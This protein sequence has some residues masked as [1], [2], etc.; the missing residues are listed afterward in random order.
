M[1][2]RAFLFVLG[3]AASLWSDPIR[4]QQRQ[5]PLVAFLSPRMPQP[6]FDPTIDAFRQGLRELGYVEG[7]NI[8]V[9]FRY[10]GGDTE[11]APSSWRLAVAGEVA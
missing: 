2:R 8:S 6:D 7:Q 9:E 3:S 4:S 11:R 5:I 10:A 1:R